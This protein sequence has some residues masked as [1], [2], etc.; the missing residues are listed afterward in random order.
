MRSSLDRRVILQLKGCEKGDY[1]RVAWFDANDQHG[2]LDEIRKKPEVLIDDWG[3][4]LGV[5]GNPQYIIL[6]KAYIPEERKYDATC[7]H[8]KLV[9]NVA[10]I[11]KHVCKIPRR[12]RVRY[13]KQKPWRKW[14]T[15][16]G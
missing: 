8:L 13:S 12:Y 9:Q 5:E 3:L 14:V 2:T 11:A 15:I 16:H 6:G 1:I 10:L 4:F 7:I